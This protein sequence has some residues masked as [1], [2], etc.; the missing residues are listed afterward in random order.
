MYNHLQ[1]SKMFNVKLIWHDTST[2]KSL[3]SIFIIYTIVFITTFYIL[4]LIQKTNPW[5]NI[6]DHFY[7]IWIIIFHEKS[8]R[9]WSSRKSQFF[10]FYI[11]N[12]KV[13]FL[14][15]HVSLLLDP[16]EPC[17]SMSDVQLFGMVY[18]WEPAMCRNI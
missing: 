5:P 17:M 18:F 6:I 10:L 8:D 2:Q 3:I 13:L 11:S 1:S 15:F 16:L 12:R 7:C 9:W 14:V 4:N